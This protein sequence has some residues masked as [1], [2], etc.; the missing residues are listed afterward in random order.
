[1]SR[2]S[3]GGI[4]SKSSSRDTRC[5]ECGSRRH[6]AGDCQFRA[7]QSSRR[8][9]SPLSRAR[10]SRNSPKRRRSRSRSRQHDDQLDERSP[11]NH[12]N[13]FPVK[14]ECSRSPRNVQNRSPSA[15][16]RVN[17]DSPSQQIGSSKSLQND[18]INLQTDGYHSSKECEHSSSPRSCSGRSPDVQKGFESDGKFSPVVSEPDLSGS[19][20]HLNCGD[21]PSPST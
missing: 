13:S 20:E 16:S 19:S 1:M 12:E 2:R 6:N 17:E 9:S 14:S 21:S 11:R 4:R 5:R 18:L 3:S 8:S 7:S 10:T 15:H